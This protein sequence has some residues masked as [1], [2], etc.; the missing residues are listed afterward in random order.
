M[1]GLTT[2]CSECQTD[3]EPQ[4]ITITFERK[5]VR[6]AMSGIPARVCPNCGTKYMPGDIAGDVIRYSFQA[7]TPSNLRNLVFIH[8]LSM[9]AVQQ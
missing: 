8:V 3:T 4:E 6:T 9:L 1:K 7:E 5:G 2:V